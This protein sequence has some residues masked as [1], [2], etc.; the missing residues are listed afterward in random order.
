VSAVPDGYSAKAAKASRE[1]RIFIDWMRNQRGATAITP[2]SSS[3]AR[4]AG[5]DAG[6][7]GGTAVDRE[8]PGVH[9]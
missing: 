4:P 5:R 6:F 8:C 7:V 1:N 2:Y 9:D 3:E